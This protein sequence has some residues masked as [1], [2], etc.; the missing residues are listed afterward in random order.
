M[1]ILLVLLIIFVSC[2][3]ES[4]EK[5]FGKIICSQNEI[6][7]GSD[8]YALSKL[9]SIENVGSGRSNLIE[10][11]PFYSECNMEICSENYTLQN[12]KCLEI[13]KYC[14]DSKGVG[15][16]TY[17]FETNEY[18]SC[19]YS[20]CASGHELYNNECIA[21]R[22]DCSEG[23]GSGFSYLQVLPDTYSSCLIN[24]CTDDFFL[25]NSSC[26]PKISECVDSSGTGFK[27][28]D[29]ISNDY[30]ECV[31]NSCF[32][33]ILFNG[34]CYDST[35]AC[36]A[37]VGIGT[38][39]FDAQLGTYGECNYSSCS[40]EFNLVGDECLADQI[41]CSIPK[42]SGFRS[43]VGSEYGPCIINSCNDGYSLIANNCHETQTACSDETGEGFNYIQE[44]TSYSACKKNICYSGYSMFEE[45]CFSSRLSCDEDVGTGFQDFILGSYE[46]CVFSSCS[47]DYQFFENK[48]II[49]VVSCEEDAYFGY[50]DIVAAPDT[51]SECK[52]DS[53]KE[54]YIL[55]EGICK[56]Q[57]KISLITNDFRVNKTNYDNF[58]V[59]GYCDTEG[60]VFADFPSLSFE[61]ECSNGLFSFYLNFDKED[62]QSEA[63]VV[64]RYV[65][66][67]GLTPETITSIFTKDTLVAE[68]Q[69]N[70]FF[71]YFDD[72]LSEFYILSGLCSIDEDNLDITIDSLLIKTDC[73][74]FDF[75]E[76][77]DLRYLSYGKY[78]LNFK[79]YDDHGNEN[80]YPYQV[81]KVPEMLPEHVDYC[82]FG[83]SFYGYCKIE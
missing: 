40:E 33:N 18:N 31:Y 44:D 15:N 38:Q 14:A 70:P 17:N 80:N 79:S 52:L 73:S 36:P 74:S 7:Q 8:C 35:V 48:C 20:E 24:S 50:R 12:S 3:E 62:E 9:C 47:E 65:D 63:P 2:S 71:Q 28:Y 5:E 55:D 29:S 68:L 77:L 19:V 30:G 11:T 57:S 58:F 21:D 51:Y 23:E 27:Y 39:I 60:T 78:S 56:V 64:F 82:F 43:L 41:V 83:S 72:F 37:E 46:E 66:S 42:G 49:K 76:T 81:F 69:I 10:G 75:N 26:L 32:N 25:K 53:C 61:S 34:F 54:G 4:T 22:I 13:D 45:E 59:Q 6:Q 16:T 1:R 67:Y